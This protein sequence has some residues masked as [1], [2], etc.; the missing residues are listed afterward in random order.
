MDLE[1]RHGRDLQGV[2][3][4]P[5]IVGPRAGIEHHGISAAGKRVQALDERA[6]VVGVEEARREAQLATVPLDLAL[7]L[8]ERERAVQQRITPAQLVQVDPVHHL[9]AVPTDAHRVSSSTAARS[10]AAS[11]SVSWLTSPGART[12]TN[13]TPPRRRFLSKA[14]ASSTASTEAP[15]RATGSPRSVSSSRTRPRSASVRD[16]RSAP[17]RATPTASP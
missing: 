8:R 3:D 6:L 9:H 12:S 5:R 10:S 16:R 13:G 14:R 7:E 11:T 2:A 4:R 15:A 1:G 17:S